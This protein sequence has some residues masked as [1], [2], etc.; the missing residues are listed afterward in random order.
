MNRPRRSGLPPL[1]ALVL[2]PAPLSMATAA[3]LPPVAAAKAAPAPAAGAA[4]HPRP[5]VAA[6]AK[7]SADDDHRV[8][9]LGL[10]DK[11][12]GTSTTVTLKPGGRFRF[13]RISGILRTC[14][15]TP[16]YERR[17]SAAFVQ[18]AEQIQPVGKKAPLPPKLVFSGWLFAELPSLNSFVHPVYD[19]WLR[20]CTMSFP[21]GP[22]APAG[23]QAPAAKTDSARPAP[24][25]PAGNAPAGNAAPEKA[26]APAER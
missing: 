22:P 15:T 8:A 14:E 19:V 18:V 26:P 17:Q 20:S 4:T 9:V 13:G 12:L 5:P 23:R 7:A 25:A 11:R 24:S 10:L 2:L 1:A 6:P 3:P 16:P 21:E